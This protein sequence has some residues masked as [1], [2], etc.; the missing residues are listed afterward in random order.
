MRL[1]MPAATAGRGLVINSRVGPELVTGC[2]L[3]AMPIGKL[4]RELT[5][6]HRPSALAMAC[7]L[8]QASSWRRHRATGRS[9]CGMPARERRCRRS[10]AIRE[11]SGP[12]PSRRTA[13]SWRRHRATGRSGFRTPARERRC[14]SSRAIRERSGPWPSRRT[15]SSWRRHHGTRRSGCG[16]PARE[17]RGRTS[18][19]STRVSQSGCRRHSRG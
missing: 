1:Y 4:R 13:R 12:W 15:A 7:L 14:R 6:G 19:A 16:T 11:R 9:G 3:V 17:R 5:L 10:R 8:R 18:L 2:P